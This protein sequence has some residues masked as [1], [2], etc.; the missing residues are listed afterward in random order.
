MT[1]LA[2]G[3]GRGGGRIIYTGGGFGGEGDP[4]KPKAPKRTKKPKVPV[5]IGPHPTI[6]TPNY[7]CRNKETIITVYLDHPCT[8]EY[9]PC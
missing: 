7:C 6:F 8:D 3:G 2:I 1:V 9:Y 5:T 4:K